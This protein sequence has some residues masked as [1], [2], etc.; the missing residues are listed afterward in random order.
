MLPA[1]CFR[2]NRDVPQVLEPDDVSLLLR[3]NFNSSL[4]TKMYAH[5]L[6]GLPDFGYP[7]KDGY[8]LKEDC[9]F[10]CVD[11]SVMATGNYSYVGTYYVPLAGQLTGAFV[12]FLTAQTGAPLDSFHLIGHRFAASTL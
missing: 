1:D 5:G 12:N 9:N 2:K 11:W 7:S 3:S 4:P 6:G 10:I 8:L